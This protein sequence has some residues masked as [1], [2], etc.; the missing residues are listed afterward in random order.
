M[1]GSWL[2]PKAE[3]RDAGET[4]CGIFAISVVEPGEPIAVWT[5]T[6][7]AAG[8][9][10]NLPDDRRAR[11]VQV[12]LDVY[13]VPEELAPGDFV[14]HSCNPNAGLAGD[15]TLVAMRRIL[16]GEEITYDY[17]MTDHAPYDEFICACGAPSCRGR[18]RGGDWQRPE[19]QQRY[20]GF[21]SPYLELLSRMR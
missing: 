21:F 20:Q 2:T 9:F 11:S 7:V 16:P 6:L 1:R 17:A 8:E 3:S 5:G 12:A 13:L 14:N 18:V 15:R 10:E 19:L 4:G